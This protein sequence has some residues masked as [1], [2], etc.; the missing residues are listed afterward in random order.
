M[1]QHLTP[2]EPGEQPAASFVG[3]RHPIVWHTPSGAQPGSLS[4]ELARLLL[5][6]FTQ[7]G[8]LV[9]DVDD[10]IAFAATAA[11]TGRRHHAVGGHAA[12]PSIGDASGYID[13]I[14]L[15]WPRAAGNP[16]LLLEACRALLRTTGRLIIAVHVESGQR[17]A[18]LA[19][20]SG[21]GRTAGLR[22]T[23]HIVAVAPSGIAPGISGDT[24]TGTAPGPHTDLLIFQS[25][26]G[27]DD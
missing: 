26:A 14:L 2:S 11:A 16:L 23:A 5:D 19:A 3:A 20:L 9:V 17:P 7:A 4:P 8:A 22:I 10:D 12:L 18:H 21:A 13:L 27:H 24:R 1:D 15:H 25:E 6:S